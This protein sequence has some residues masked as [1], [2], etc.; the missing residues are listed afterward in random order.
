MSNDIATSSNIKNDSSI[1]DVIAYTNYVNSLTSNSISSYPPVSFTTTPYA[2]VY[3]NYGSGIQ[4]SGITTRY[5]YDITYSD[6]LYE[7][8]KDFFKNG[9]L[10]KYKEA[11]EFF[12]NISS[13]I[14]QDIIECMDGDDYDKVTSLASLYKEASIFKNIKDITYD[15]NS[16]FEFDIDGETYYVANCFFKSSQNHRFKILFDKKEFSNA[17]IRK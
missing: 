2:P 1:N 4:T 5:E 6:S 14:K 7:T 12:T 17:K 9:K 10:R 8:L 3:P 13:K 15:Q 16:V 11:I